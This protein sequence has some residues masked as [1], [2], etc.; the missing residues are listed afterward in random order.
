M[1]YFIYNKRTGEYLEFRD[2]LPEAPDLDY[3]TEP[4][5]FILNAQAE[6]VK[7]PFRINNHWEYRDRFQIHQE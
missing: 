4:T 7:I 3:T 2:T 5:D 6:I 1:L